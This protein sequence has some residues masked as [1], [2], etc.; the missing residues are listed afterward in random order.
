MANEAWI[1]VDIYGSPNAMSN[2]WKRVDEMAA[3]PLCEPSKYNWDLMRW[4]SR[5]I[6]PGIAR[7]RV[8]PSS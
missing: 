2:L 3:E 4:G 8:V 6:L 5:R 1:R 7:A